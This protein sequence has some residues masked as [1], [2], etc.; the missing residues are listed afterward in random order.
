MINIWLVYFT[1]LGYV[2][3]ALDT[4]VRTYVGSESAFFNAFWRSVEVYFF[5]LFVSN[6]DKGFETHFSKFFGIL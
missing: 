3:Q 4:K 1:S 5:V 6:L 2:R